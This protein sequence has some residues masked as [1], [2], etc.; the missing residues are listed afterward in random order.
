MDSPL[1]PHFV[2]AGHTHDNFKFWVIEQV[3][4][5]RG[6]DIQRKLLQRE[7]YGIHKLNTIHQFG[8]NTTQ[9]LSCFL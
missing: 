5:E 3:I 7:A 4:S 8:L 6:H 1:V 2:N 9:D